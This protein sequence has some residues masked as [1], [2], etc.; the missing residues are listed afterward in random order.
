MRKKTLA[1]VLCILLTGLAIYSY[2]FLYDLKEFKN[3]TAIKG[4]PTNAC[5]ILQI[6]RPQKLT[7][8]LQEDIDFGKELKMFEWYVTFDSF[9]AKLDTTE[10]YSEFLDIIDVAN[11][12]LTISLHK[13]GNGK[14]VPLF[15]YK[16]KN[17]AEEN[18]FLGVIEEGLISTWKVSSREYNSTSIFKISDSYIDGIFYC[19][20]NQ[21]LLVIS[22][23]SLL[24]ENS[25]RQTQTGISLVENPT[26]NKIFKTA[27]ANCDANLFVNFFELPE[28]ISPLFEK[29]YGKS[30][31]F[32]KSI[33]EW[34]EFDINL[35]S[36][37][38]NINGFI[39]PSVTQRD[40]HILFKGIDSS[41]SDIYDVIPADSKFLLCYNVDKSSKLHVNFKEYLAVRG[42]SEK[43]NKNIHSVEGEEL[44]KELF[45]MMDE[46]FGLVYSGAN[47]IGSIE[48]A[49]IILQTKSKS[50]SLNGFEKLNAGNELHVVSV[51]KLD[52]NTEYSIYKNPNAKGVEIIFDYFFPESPSEYFAYYEN[53]LIMAN[54]VTA[55]KSFIY[56]NVLKKTLA[57]SKYFQD[58]LENYSYK[59][60]VFCYVDIAQ[61]KGFLGDKSNFSLF[62]PDKDQSVALSNFYGIG[63]QGTKANDL[64]YVNT[65]LKYLPQRESE[66]RTI[67]QSG[68]DS[69]IFFKPSLVENH[70]TGEKE[71]L[72]QD[73]ANNLYL[74]ANN[75]KILWK[76]KLESPILGE[77]FQID[78][79]RNSK[80]QYLFNTK[81]RLYLLDRNGNY[82]EKYPI[83]FAHP[84]TNGIALFDYDNNRNYRLF[85]A[86]NNKETYC[87]DKNGKRIV[88]WK[89]S[90][91][92]GIVT[93]PIQHF[94]LDNKDYIV[95]SDEKR[96]YLLDRR[97]D[98]RVIC[99]TSF[100]RNS[101]SVFYE[102]GKKIITTDT[103]GNVRKINMS[104]GTVDKVEL[105]NENVSHYFTCDDVTSSAGNEYVLVTNEELLVYKN[106]GKKEFS[107]KIDGKI[108]PMAD[109]YQ[110]SKTNKKIG[111]FDNENNRIYLINN[112]GSVYR[113]FPLKGLSRF[114]IGFLSSNSNH[115]NLIVGGANNFLYN[116]RVE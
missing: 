103:E 116:Y 70:N 81:D 38:L 66:P 67:W 64:M 111:L 51:Y 13:E 37:Q 84:A 92:E 91:T 31:N 52:D 72:V 61:L 24:V 83:N 82:V 36:S 59:D 49:A 12:E 102:E 16:L 93:Q 78:F 39:Y 98:E 45:E 79:Y 30:V 29:G 104:D 115:F 4:I 15:V 86:C 47:T 55:I 73:K 57:N 2:L 7:E 88:G 44:E 100:I 75:G 53:Y 34:G 27:G 11:R 95:Y 56:S 68:L 96:N 85:V 14:A 33:G 21:G 48:N 87:F 80:L 28:L 76:K 19:T 69:T 65:C 32:L 109:I 89:A 43:Y 1:F 107:K 9:L 54:S 20:V 112:E 8:I 105:L 23:S 62:S 5:L 50:K 42:L 46:E 97:G 74:I 113:N 17:K 71:I 106:N 3:N 58:F 18:K 101:N 6:D 60:N 10:F 40:Y 114:S 25:L 35:N 99:K 94:R 41:S 90:K 108:F 22:P 110:F 26:F 77:V 63:I